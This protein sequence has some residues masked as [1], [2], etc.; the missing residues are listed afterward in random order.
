MRNDPSLVMFVEDLPHVEAAARSSSIPLSTH[1]K[2]INSSL[3]SIQFIASSVHSLRQGLERVKEEVAIMQ[4]MPLNPADLFVNAMVPFIKKAQPAVDLLGA[5]GQALENEL[6]DLLL[7]FAENT[8]GSEATKPE[9]L[10]NLLLSFS[11]ALQVK[12]VVAAIYPE[13]LILLL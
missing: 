4:S 13:V 12:N 8:E 11:S 9:D 6:K 3:V 7:Y 1:R 5:S 10:F 2:N